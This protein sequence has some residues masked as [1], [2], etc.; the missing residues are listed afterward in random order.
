MAREADLGGIPAARAP[1][2][3]QK[4]RRGGP[5]GFIAESIAELK[6]VEW[7]GQSQVIQGTVVVL[8]ACVIV[9]AYLY[10]NDQLWQRVVQKVL[11]R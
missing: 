4:A 7:P 9:G 6:K 10:L 3:V 11:L 2:E 1:G 5:F 8:V